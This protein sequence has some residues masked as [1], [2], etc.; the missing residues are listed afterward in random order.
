MDAAAGR[1]NAKVLTN[2]FSAKVVVNASNEVATRIHDFH[3][4]L[5]L[6]DE[7]EFLES[8]RWSSAAIDARDGVV[9]ASK[10]GLQTVGRF[11]SETLETTRQSTGRLAE[12]IAHRLQRTSDS[13]EIE[14]P[15]H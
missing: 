12:K 8:R 9:G 7:R 5:G 13:S 14:G 11:G 6:A 15:A 1:A 10:D 3:F 4:T 2:P